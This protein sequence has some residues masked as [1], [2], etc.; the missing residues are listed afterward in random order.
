MFLEFFKIAM[1][2]LCGETIGKVACIP[3]LCQ[4]LNHSI[5]GL[6]Q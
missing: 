2:A 3:Q 5:I 6:L 4:K 1:K